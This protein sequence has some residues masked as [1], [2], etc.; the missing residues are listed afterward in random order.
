LIV[1]ISL[2]SILP[3]NLIA[4]SKKFVIEYISVYI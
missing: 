4:N 3:Y 1:P 2:Y